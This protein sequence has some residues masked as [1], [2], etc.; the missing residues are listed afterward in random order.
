[1]SAR[2]GARHHFSKLT[3]DLVRQM[4]EWYAE[5]GISFLEISHEFGVTES[6]ARDAIRGITW[7]HV[8]HPAIRDCESCNGT[9]KIKD[10]PRSSISKTGL[11][12]A[13]TIMSASFSREKDHECGQ[14]P[15]P[16]ITFRSGSVTLPTSTFEYVLRVLL[17]NQNPQSQRAA[18]KIAPW[19]DDAQ[20]GGCG[21]EA[22]PGKGCILD[23]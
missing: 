18:Q 7:R 14:I 3:P 17:S 5:G 4:R 10:G 6:T 16:M 23:A 19:L 21:Q 8:N 2:T 9:G 20:E 13:E 1:M 11:S 12:S 22:C 15:A